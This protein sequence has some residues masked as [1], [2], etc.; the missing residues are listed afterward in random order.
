MPSDGQTAPQ[1]YSAADNYADGHFP[2]DVNVLPPLVQAQLAQYTVDLVQEQK[3][4]RTN[5]AC[6]NCRSRKIKCSGDRPMCKACV[7]AGKQSG[8]M[9]TPCDYPTGHAKRKR[10]VD[11]E[12]GSRIEPAT[13]T[14]DDEEESDSEAE[15]VRMRR[16]SSVAKERGIQA[17]SDSRSQA[18]WDARLRQDLGLMVSPDGWLES[19]LTGNLSTN[20][21]N[22][23]NPSGVI[24]TTQPTIG[25]A[26]SEDPPATD[27][28]QRTGATLQPPS[29]PP[30]W[31]Q[32]WPAGSHMPQ[33]SPSTSTSAGPFGHIGG[34]DIPSGTQTIPRVFTAQQA[35][36]GRRGGKLRVPYFRQVCQVLRLVSSALMRSADLLANFHL[37]HCSGT[38]KCRQHFGM[39]L[40]PQSLIEFCI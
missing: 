2:F 10:K 25:W 8:A 16:K 36:D 28:T 7:K 17:Q 4:P 33:L 35:R 40:Y 9:A 3:L 27:Q 30:P 19:P 26:A 1:D 29:V 37:R 39:C 14:I 31:G 23:H 38:C 21:P 32:E 24:L 22:M 6:L 15:H 13:N 34:S 20:G 12:S 11:R 5:L 18:L